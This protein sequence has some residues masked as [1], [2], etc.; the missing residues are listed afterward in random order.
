MQQASKT[1]IYKVTRST[2]QF[3]SKQLNF[4][5]GIGA[6]TSKTESLETNCKV[7]SNLKYYNRIN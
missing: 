4:Y 5:T 1:A 7:L 6:K 2:M 3:Q